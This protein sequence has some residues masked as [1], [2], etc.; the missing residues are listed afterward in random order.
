MLGIVC[1]GVS[2]CSQ[3]GGKTLPTYEV[4]RMAYD[5][6]LAIEGYTES[7]N[8]L[9]ISCPPDVDGTIVR[10]VE[11]GEKV[12]EGDVICIIEDAE[13]AN[14]Y[15]QWQLEL[16]SMHA[17][18]EKLKASQE[19]E[20]AL[21]EAQLR[22]NDVET[23]LAESDSL[24]MLYMSPKEREIKKLQLERARIER[25]QLIRKVEATKELQKTD[26]MKIE[27][28]IAKTERRLEDELKKIE[29]LTLRAPRDGIA[30]RA[31]R[32][33]WGEETWN[34][35]DNVWNGRAVIMM[36][37]L[38]QMKILIYAQEADYKRI[39]QG[40]SV[41]YT[42]DAMPG[43]MGWGRIERLSPV[44]QMRTEGS[45]VKTFEIEATLDSLLMPVD[46]GLSVQ[47]K[48]YLRHVPDT[49]V[50]PTISVFDKDSLKVVYV[51]HGGRFEERVVSLGESSPRSSI[52]A[53]G[54]LPGEK[55]SL[56]KPEGD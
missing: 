56:I 16:E 23:L 11:T 26:V 10:I 42:F 2:S 14:N 49:I 48:V 19:L 28:Q 40:D 53:S 22:N 12:K 36:P 9:T 20:T 1:C 24:Q 21:L 44:G 31:R 3:G 35:G 13:I 27:R 43:N 6:V 52:V 54:L 55:I 29:S 37:D 17:E 47:C 38:E 30:I 34:I 32:R 25:D 39:Q 7:L 46:P 8:S 33:P 18:M 51:L 50:V 5:D 15:D 45:S 4:T 41:T